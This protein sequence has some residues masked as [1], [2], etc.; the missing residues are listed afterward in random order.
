MKTN[1][2]YK[3]TALAAL[4][5]NWTPAVLLGLVIMLISSVSAA[6]GFF[7]TA[8]SICVTM[9][10]TV[11]V[12]VVF[13]ELLHG[14]AE[15]MTE[16]SFKIGF[17]NWSHNTGGMLLMGVYVFL[18]TLLL[19]VPGVIK[20]LSYALTPFILHDKPELSANEA[21][22]L[23][24]EMMEGRKM[25]LFLLYLGFLGWALLCLLTLCIGFLWLEPYIYATIAAFY[26]DVKADY[27]SRN[28]VVA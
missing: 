25:D 4:K 18:W 11:G 10:L 20:A 8:V 3:E 1:Q 14:N 15:K 24:M 6:S 23:S 9:P 21:I 12:C 16:R 27:E 26:E 17:A 28:A 22:E 5:G 19:I 2:E 7:S 13:R